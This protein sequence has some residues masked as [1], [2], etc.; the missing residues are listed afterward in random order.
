MLPDANSARWE[1]IKSH[2]SDRKWLDASPRPKS[3][4]RFLPGYEK[5]RVAKSFEKRQWDSSL[6]RDLAVRAVAEVLSGA[7]LDELADLERTGQLQEWRDF[8]LTS[9]NVQMI[10]SPKECL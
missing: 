2:V 3:W 8:D 10:A 6:S 4:W 9:V 5:G 1:W 7:T